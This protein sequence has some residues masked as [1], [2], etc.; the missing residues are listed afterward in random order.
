MHYLHCFNCVN[1]I[2]SWAMSCTIITFSLVFLCLQKSLFRPHSWR[3]YS[4]NIEFG[5]ES[6]FPVS[7]YRCSSLRTSG[8]SSFCWEV[9][10]IQ[11]LYEICC[12]SSFQDFLLI[13]DFQ[14]LGY[15]VFRQN[16]FQIY[17]IWGLLRFLG[18]EFS[19]RGTREVFS[20]SI[21][22]LL[23]LW[24]QRFLFTCLHLH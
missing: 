15:E 12:F 11:I 19:P 16:S 20:P 6:S 2:P 9:Q 13:F 8:F 10:L 3:I 14:Q 18:S 7:S 1:I 24:I 5:V 4:V 21:F 17:R 22:F 23:L